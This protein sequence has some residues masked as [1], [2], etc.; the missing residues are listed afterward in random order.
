MH[1]PTTWRIHALF[2]VLLLLCTSLIQAQN[3]ATDLEALELRVQ[4][5]HDSIRAMVEVQPEQLS[6]LLDEIESIKAAEERKFKLFNQMEWGKA[7]LIGL[8]LLGGGVLL[9]FGI[10]RISENSLVDRLRVRQKFLKT[11]LSRH[12]PEYLIGDLVHEE[13]ISPMVW[14]NCAVLQ[15]DILENK[16]FDTPSERISA[17]DNLFKACEGLSQNHGIIQVKNTGQKIVAVCKSSNLTP[18]E[19]ANISAGCLNQLRSTMETQ[20]DSGLALK[21]G[22]T[23]GDVVAGLTKSGNKTSFDI[24][25]HPV[26]E[27]QEITRSSRP[28]TIS[29]TKYIARSLNKSEFSINEAEEGRYEL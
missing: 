19:Q 23:Y 21:A 7:T 28:G 20:A 17:M 5:S 14:K 6:R 22:I 24:W 26:Q 10:V 2:A 16:P 11:N 27:V 9:I 12:I 8:I 18:M 29:T 4:Q 13:T 25:G 1:Q 3:T 15:V